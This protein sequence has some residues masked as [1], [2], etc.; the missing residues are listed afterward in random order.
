MA[1]PLGIVVVDLECNG[2]GLP[3]FA[4]APFADS[5]VLAATLSRL[6]RCRSV[7]QWVLSVPTP[8]ID[9]VRNLAGSTF[10]IEPIQAPAPEWRDKIRRARK[11]SLRGWRG[12]IARSSMLDEESNPAEFA[13]LARAHHAD[14]VVQVRAESPLVDP[15]LLDAIVDRYEHTKPK[16]PLLYGSIPP[17]LAGW[18]LRPDFLE[19]LAQNELHPGVVLGYRAWEPTI[20][21]TE[22]LFAYKPPLAVSSMRQRFLADN[23]ESLALLRDLEAS[24]A[25][26]SAESIGQWMS[27][28]SESRAGAAPAE[29][30]IEI[31][32]HRLHATPPVVDRP[33]LSVADFRAIV[34]D[35]AGATD[36]SLVMLQGHGDPLQ[37][38]EWPQMI[39]AART[40]G[41]YGIALATDALSLQP[42][43]VEALVASD[44]DVLQV[45]WPTLARDADQAAKLLDGFL[46]ARRRRGKSHPLLVVSMVRSRATL[47][48]MADF[49]DAWSTKADAA[50]ITPHRDYAGQLPGDS[51]LHL[52][53]PGRSACRR[54]SHTMMIHSDGAVAT[55]SEDFLARQPC[56][57]IDERGLAF[58]WQ[59]GPLAE[60]RDRH[61]RGE[62]SLLALCAQCRDWHRY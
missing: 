9:A 59:S 24:D 42:H 5:T 50:V 34:A 4:A 10:P 48:Q 28:H 37:H 18:V 25:G 38:C 3:S 1:S 60:I 40:A 13:R 54:L 7:Q 31:T 14:C 56:G 11:W 36:L 49:Y 57:K 30:E 39:A 27:A 47:E 35:Y 26:T 43:V 44:L 29:L 6:R 41:V 62:W 45:R 15:A 12:G 23:R 19:E 2:L 33:E 51:V 55:C 32:T 53:P 52:E 61:A 58:A 16:P 21:L 8:Q 22:Q 20:D 17:G 46:D